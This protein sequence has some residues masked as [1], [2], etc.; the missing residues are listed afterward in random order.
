MR[1]LLVLLAIIGSGLYLQAQSTTE[2]K[3]A[4]AA[5]EVKADKIGI[6]LSSDDPE[7]AWN[8]FRFANYAQRKGDTVSVFL[9]G[10][11]VEA[12]GIK[13]KE[14]DVSGMMLEY[15]DGGGKIMACGTC[16]ASRNKEG[17]KL[18]PV[19]SLSDLYALIKTS[20]IVLTF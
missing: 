15:T 8:A 16:L 12:P 17:S 6:V 19:S 9:L 7:T 4:V 20:N 13:D 3:D 18:C 5:P 10:K 11:G 1:K 2:C 14:F